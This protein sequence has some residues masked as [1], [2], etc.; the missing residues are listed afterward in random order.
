M[1][2]NLPLTGSQ[3]VKDRVSEGFA[4]TA[5][6][7]DADGR[8]FFGQV[9]TWL[10]ETAHI[11]AGAW[12]LDVGC[13]KGAA[14]VP[15]A[16]A[17]DPDGHVTGIDLAAPML[18]HARDRA[19]EVGLANVT[20]RD[21]DAEDPGRHP[22]WPPGSFDVILAA[23]VIQFLPLPGRAAAHWRALLT[24]HGRLGV[25]WTV[26]QDPRWRPV[27]AAIDA[28]VP[29][30]VPAFGTFMRRPPFEDVAAFEAMLTGAG[31]RDV[32]TVTRDITMAYNGP[33]QWWATYQTQGPWA[34][35]W[36]HIPG[37]RL[38]QAKADAAR[39][40]EPLREADGTITRTLTFAV[41]TARRGSW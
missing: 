32:A 41:T 12:V 36:R 34:V 25:A 24:P 35:S 1:T 7:Y 16:Q 17:A 3:T 13:G 4:A 31:Y 9:G 11:P 6:A 39:L 29:D 21:G 2:G 5:D 10:A 33:D 18:A 22:G 28:H 26:G 15:A 20:F 19:R 38:A 27:I 37:D 40:L 23:N 14:S 8:E 30:G